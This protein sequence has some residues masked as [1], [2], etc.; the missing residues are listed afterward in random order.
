MA[1]YVLLCILDIAN[2]SISICNPMSAMTFLAADVIF[3]YPG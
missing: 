2:V 3:P 1:V